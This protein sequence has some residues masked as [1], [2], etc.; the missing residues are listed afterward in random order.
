MKKIICAVITTVLV[1]GNF[2]CN[3]F[4]EEKLPPQDNIMLWVSADECSENVGDKVVKWNDKSG[5]GNDLLAVNSNRSPRMI[6]TDK[7]KTTKALHFAKNNYM[8]ANGIDY[9]GDATLVLYY[10]QQSNAEG[11]T[12]FS[13]H[14]YEKNSVAEK[15][16]IPFKI[17]TDSNGTLLFDMQNI[18]EDG[19]Q[20]GV[21]SESL[22]ITPS[23]NDYMALYITFEAKSNTVRVYVKPVNDHSAIEEPITEFTTNNKLYWSDVAYNLNYSVSEIKGVVA[24]YAE[25]IIY[26]KALTIDEL[27]QVNE[28][29]KLK[30]EYPVVKSLKLKN[31]I[32]EIKYGE[33]VTPE[34]IGIG[35]MMGNVNE[36]LLNNAVITS[37]N[38][39]IVKAD[40]G[41]L[42]AVNYGTALIKITY[43]GADDLIISVRVPSLQ[44]IESNIDTPVSGN[45][46]GCSCTVE[47]FE[48]TPMSILMIS[49]L[50]RGD[51]LVDVRLDEADVIG[52]HTFNVKLSPQ[53]DTENLK[54][55]VMLLDGENMYPIADSL[56]K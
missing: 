12:V 54:V 25:S 32:S 33:S 41:V 6:E 48:S 14:A 2:V 23:V 9:C 52:E 44:V 40:N 22:N 28:Y 50:K 34:V 26:K 18:A 3:V 42:T 30:Y 56:L 5:N 31:D 45:E 53:N 37:L 17:T 35:N 4:C 16:K 38:N 24:D 39:D 55:S 43:A 20:D 36:Y 8:V 46:I 27:N 47:N 1:V 19:T 7:I 13:S 11:D 10:C 21:F 51:E 29:L 15:S 49:V